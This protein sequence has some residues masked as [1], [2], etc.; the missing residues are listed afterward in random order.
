[1][2]CVIRGLFQELS[3]LSTIGAYSLFSFKK[4]I[5]RMYFP[6]KNTSLMHDDIQTFTL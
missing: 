5:L 4:A 1:M 6:F 2:L 3:L